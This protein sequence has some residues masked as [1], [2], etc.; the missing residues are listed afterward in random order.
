MPPHLSL[1]LRAGTGESRF[2]VGL[3]ATPTRKDGHHPIIFMQCGPIRYHASRKV[4]AGEELVQQVIPRHTEFRLQATVETM[5]EPGIQDIFAAL[6]KDRDRL[7]LIVGDVLNAVE[8][9]SFP[10]VLTGRREQVDHFEERLKEGIKNVVILRGGM[11]SKQRQAVRD[12]IAG[13]P[14]ASRG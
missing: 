2:V 14:E 10:L 4:Q 12:E 1:Q 8:S 5:P 9:G 3:T 7:G 11:G 13:L 6:G